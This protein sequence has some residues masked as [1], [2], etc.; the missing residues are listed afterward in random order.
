MSWRKKK[1]LV[2]LEINLSKAQKVQIASENEAIKL[3][4]SVI[5][6]YAEQH[7]SERVI[8]NGTIAVFLKCQATENDKYNGKQMSYIFTLNDKN[9]ENFP[10]YDFAKN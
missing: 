3:R 10:A 5:A 9:A 8:W 2:K 1:D 7:K 6:V 4:Q